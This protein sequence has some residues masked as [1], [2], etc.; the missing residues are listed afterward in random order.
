MRF[1]T[2]CALALLG[3]QCSSEGQGKQEET[4]ADSVQREAEINRKRQEEM[5]LQS[6]LAEATDKRKRLEAMLAHERDE[7]RRTALTMQLEEARA[8]E[9]K[10]AKNAG[11]AAPS[12]P[13]S[14]CACQ[15]TD[16]VCDCR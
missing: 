10:A 1:L 4:P 11:L 3:I 8:A 9:T 13:T 5:A 14:G 15:P 6:K 16:P 7:G 12:A 2:V